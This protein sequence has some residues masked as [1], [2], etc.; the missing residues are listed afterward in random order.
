MKVFRVFIFFLFTFGLFA[1]A[2]V[3]VVRGQR[4]PNE[5]Y[6]S[7][8]KMR[9][10]IEIN[11][12]YAT[13]KIM[14]IFK[15]HK[16]H[17][18]EGEYI[19]TMP[20]KASISD[21][22]V[23]DDGNRVKGIILE[24]SKARKL[25]EKIKARLVDPGLLEKR[26]NFSVNE[27]K[28]NIFPIRPDSYKRIEIQYT[29]LLP[30]NFRNLSF[31]LPL[32]PVIFKDYTLKV[33][34]LEFNFSY[35]GDSDFENLKIFAPFDYKK[36]SSY[37]L[38]NG[39]ISFGYKGKNVYLDRDFLFNLDYVFKKTE[40][41]LKTYRDIE[42]VR[43]DYSPANN[44]KRY[45]DE[46]GYFKGDFYLS[47]DIKTEKSKSGNIVLVFDNSLS[48]KWLK[49]S[50]AFEVF[51]FLIDRLDQKDRF[52]FILFS[53]KVEYVFKDFKIANEKNKNEA[54]ERLLSAKIK[55][56]TD[57]LNLIKELK[58][59]K[60]GTFVYWITD[61]QATLGEIKDE[62]LLKESGKLNKL[63]FFIV[64]IGSD[65][66]TKFLE[67]ISSISGG[68]FIHLFENEDIKLKM[69]LFFKALNQ[70]PLENIAYS[71]GKNE[72]YKNIYTVTKGTVYD[73]SV[74]SL[75]GQYKKSIKDKIRLTYKNIKKVLEF[76]IELPEK[77]VK[78]EYIK[79]IWANERINYLLEKIDAE[80][81]KKE[82]VNEII[83][84]SKEYTIVTPYTSFLAAPRSFI[85]PRSIIPGDP[86][87][88]V[89][90]DNS[91]K[92]VLAKFEFGLIKELKYFP[93]RDIWETRFLV[94]AELKDGEYKVDLYLT[95]KNGSV[96]IETKSVTIDSTP[97]IIKVKYKINGNDL[98]LIADASKDT[99]T[100]YAYFKG[101]FV[102]LKYSK[103]E[104]HSIAVLKDANKFK[105]AKVKYI[106]EDFAHNTS[107][108]YDIVRIGE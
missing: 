55:S 64:G 16:N 84:L 96:L 104:K 61:G 50:K 44:G 48:F 49:L 88:R 67:K 4:F 5:N 82:W 38:K 23:W 37:E 10:D 2:G 47:E 83:S 33:N 107:T 102:K 70:V 97:P 89:K 94:P 60:E 106:L 40:F 71:F 63:K 35:S 17:T 93:R 9:V 39:A 41:N 42:K 105:G 21:F 22:A 81:E 53:D 1:E 32:R 74:Y 14:Q 65:C 30:V 90:T 92:S 28:V 52:K 85:R 51:S 6:L 58:K 36:N 100:I 73:K 66:D 24:K 99:K 69:N 101:N 46:N 27:F 86:V 11:S 108:F 8:E 3:I 26:N 20:D 80:G 76:N 59:E 45:K 18:L 79:R 57:I 98:K 78:N 43:I 72:N 68:Y 56:G 103:K 19:F 13:V 75:V 34:K 77:N 31:Y 25:Y 62:N 87:L 54:Y 12:L 95:E 29:E 15:N 91:I 7:L